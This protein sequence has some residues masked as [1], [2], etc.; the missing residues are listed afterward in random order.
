MKHAAL[1]AMGVALA[2]QPVYSNAQPATQKQ[3]EGQDNQAMADACHVNRSAARKHTAP[4][5]ADLKAAACLL[6]K[7]KNAGYPN[8]KWGTIGDPTY[9]QKAD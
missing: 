4:T 2:F 8:S 6:K 3:I 1:A 7:L 5:A 9:L